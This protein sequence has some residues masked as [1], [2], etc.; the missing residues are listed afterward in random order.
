MKSTRFYF[1]RATLILSAILFV[2]A[3]AGCKVDDDNPALPEGIE[4]LSSSDKLIGKWADDYTSW[5]TY[6]TYD[7]CI[8]TSYIESAS[9][10]KQEGTVYQRKIS[11]T[12]GYLY[13]QISNTTNFSYSSKDAE[14]YKGKW[15]GV[16]YTD[17]TDNSV[18]MSDACPADYKTDYAAFDSLEEARKGLTVE[19]GYFS[20]TITFTRV[21]E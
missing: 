21:S 15:Y 8:A 3:F 7:T 10:G 9:Y 20:T 11:D 1:G 12:E 18:K 16:Y 6:T 2:F 19:A 14:T 13:Y 5:N 17:L 4:E